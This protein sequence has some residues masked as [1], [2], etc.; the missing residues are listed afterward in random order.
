[1]AIVFMINERVL[2]PE[3]FDEPIVDRARFYFVPIQTST[4]AEHRFTM[5]KAK[6]TVGEDFLLP[7]YKRTD[8]EE[9]LKWI[10]SVPGR[11]VQADDNV[12]AQISFDMQTNV[13]TWQFQAHNS[14]WGIVALTGGFAIVLYY[15]FNFIVC[16]LVTK[17]FENYLASELY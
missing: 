1:M 17:K 14:I 4:A 3:K 10:E 15:V 6:L 11:L 16:C 8:I 2:N 9:N 7:F 5:S 12:L 13:Q